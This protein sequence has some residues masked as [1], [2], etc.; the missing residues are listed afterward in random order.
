MSVLAVETPHRIVEVDGRARRHQ[1]PRASRC[2]HA[3]GEERLQRRIGDPPV[4]IQRILQVIEQDHVD[5]VVERPEEV[6]DLL[7]D[8]ERCWPTP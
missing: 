3:Q 7:F 5:A 8:R 1:Q 4:R 6:L 2:S